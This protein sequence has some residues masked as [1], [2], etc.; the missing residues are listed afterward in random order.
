MTRNPFSP[1]PA[2]LPALLLLVAGTG[3]LPSKALPWT[4]D[5]GQATDVA[6][7]P[8]GTV[9]A[10]G[11][12]PAGAPDKAILVSS[13]EGWKTLPGAAVR[14]G[15]G[16]NG[17]A[18]VVNSAGDVYTWEGGSWKRMPGAAR[19]V[20]YG[21]DGTLVAAGKDGEVYRWSG[22]AW[23]KVEGDKALGAAGGA[24]SLAVGPRGELWVVA[25]KGEILRHDGRAG[26]PWKRI[27]GS[28]K[29]IA[30]GPDGT[31]LAV[32]S[33]GAVQRLMG[34][35]W[36]PERGV[37]GARIAAG[38][39]G[40]AY[41]A[42]DAAP[43][44]A[45]LTP[46]RVASAGAASAVPQAVAPTPVAPPLGRPSASAPQ[47]VPPTPAA[48]P[49]ER[50]EPAPQAPIIVP[51]GTF[52]IPA[53]AP[54]PQP[55]AISIQAPVAVIAPPV[56]QDLRPP[57]QFASLDGK[58]TDVG[59]GADGTMWMLGA[60]PVAG[61][62]PIFRHDGTSWKQM[63]GAAVR[64]AVDPKGAAWVVNAAHMIFR[65]SGSDWQQM[66][67]AATDVGAGADGTVWVIGTDGA[68]WKWTGSDWAS[69]GGIVTAIAVG[70]DG[71]PW[72]INPS[73]GVWR[74]D[75][76]SWKQLPGSGSDITVDA[77]GTVYVL[78]GSP[79]AGGHPVQR[80][81]GQSWVAEGAAGTRLAAGPA[82]RLIVA[83]DAASGGGLLTMVPPGTVSVT[84]TVIAGS[85][86]PPA[87]T[88]PIQYTITSPGQT[89]ISMPGGAVTTG[90]VPVGGG[91][92][93]GGTPSATGGSLQGG[94]TG[95]GSLLQVPGGA[96]SAPLVVSG[97][98]ATQITNGSLLCSDGGNVNST[99][100]GYT[101]AIKV[102][103][104]KTAWPHECPSGTTFESIFGG[105]CWSCGDWTRDGLKPADS[106]QACYGNVY[107]KATR[108][109][110]AATLFT[111]ATGN[112]WDGYDGGACYTCPEG[113]ERSAEH[114]A[115]D[116]GC[117]RVAHKVA[118]LKKN[119]GCP[120]QTEW[121][122]G[123]PKPF[124]DIGLNTCYACPTMDEAT[125]DV[126][127]TERSLAA[128]DT[129]QAC[130]VEVRWKPTRVT[131]LRISS[132][133]RDNA[134]PGSG[135][136]V[137]EIL[138]QPGVIN[139]FLRHLAA[140]ERVQEFAVS[141]W[142]ERRWSEMVANPSESDV[143]KALLYQRVV[144]ALQRPAGE[145]DGAE[146][147][148]L[149]AFQKQTQAR[150]VAVP[151]DALNMYLAWKR[152]VDEVRAL[153]AHN[154]SDFFYY[155]TV[156]PNFEVAAQATAAL[157]TT[158]IGTLAF[159][160]STTAYFNNI[161]GTIRMARNAEVINGFRNATE[162]IA[163]MINAGKMT[164][165][166]AKGTRALVAGRALVTG[167]Q[168]AITGVTAMAAAASVVGI[169]GSVFISIAIDQIVEIATAQ[170]KLE[171]SLDAAKA[172]VKLE[173]LLSSSAGMTKLAYCWSGML[174]I[175][176][177]PIDSTLVS[178]ANAA[179]AA[180]KASNY[181][182]APPAR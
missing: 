129:T 58:A 4:P 121:S 12:E 40:L 74:H 166:V 76:S 101:S 155:G 125:G 96:G 169:V 8:D 161:A 18:A 33:G 5:P 60:D 135:V 140:Q 64:V 97:V 172:P 117:F 170:Q 77:A 79:V 68:A 165:D 82:G 43:M 25:A 141:A 175:K 142:V 123:K 133:E 37:A 104:L 143:L 66:P 16:P 49:L 118:E 149:E 81:T 67:G 108:V 72:A 168:G 21:V 116:W 138:E 23:S 90:G 19:D 28:A 80:F 120:D 13:P 34:A 103:T 147:R 3:A 89:V 83:K 61:G 144:A 145:R 54:T 150:Q 93:S 56:L 115:G 158:G 41:L 9:W 139:G 151:Q 46:N 127:I 173:D 36:V 162:A 136:L 157:E 113:Y 119:L 50:P 11:A 15:A 17:R 126:L 51:A 148:L 180:A 106:D 59:M 146:Q 94:N 159:V 78:G 98:Y 22:N 112:I 152:S 102:G 7:A 134:L 99:R 174:E 107:T 27:P 35:Q 124:A 171:A 182:P 31:V 47:A 179:W 52:S 122:L 137:G 176:D 48:P 70:P 114:I 57:A 53:P 10:I 14:I 131:A 111:C 91:T 128:A 62:F 130:R 85:T 26:A 63:P 2:L 167:V 87:G 69:A 156:P 92:A 24:H 38:P 154:V 100:C 181:A 86:T 30:V 177:P 20:A 44:L 42:R 164:D 109:K 163:R 39:D 105:S 153:R 45:R 132:V 1:S 110:A 6:I 73:G 84:P 88:G 32:A 65:W 178:K 95:G 75:G 71:K 55:T 160:A 29:D